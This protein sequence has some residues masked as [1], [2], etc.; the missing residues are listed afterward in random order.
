MCPLLY[1]NTRLQQERNKLILHISHDL[2]NPLSA[3]LG[4]EPIQHTGETPIPE[5]V[6]Y[7]DVQPSLMMVAEPRSQYGTDSGKEN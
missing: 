2:K 4:R 7:R 1:T 3:V 6:T 5:P